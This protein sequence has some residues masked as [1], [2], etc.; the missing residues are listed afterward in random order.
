MTARNGAIRGRSSTGPQAP[1]THAQIANAEGL[2]TNTPMKLLKS[3]A[4]KVSK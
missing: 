2:T 4:L 1:T 3:A